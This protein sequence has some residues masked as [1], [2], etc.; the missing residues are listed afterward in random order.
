MSGTD[1]ADDTDGTDVPASATLV[2]AAGDE[3]GDDAGDDAGVAAAPLS[4]SLAAPQAVS[5]SSAA[6]ANPSRGRPVMAPG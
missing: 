3:A 6:A 1:G 2:E 4:P 5:S